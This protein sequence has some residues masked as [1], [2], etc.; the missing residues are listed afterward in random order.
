[1]SLHMR[2]S[3]LRAIFHLSHWLTKFDFV[4]FSKFLILENVEVPIVLTINMVERDGKAYMNISDTSVSTKLSYFKI[5]YQC[6]NVATVINNMVSTAVNSNW[7]LIKF[8]VDPTV[9]RF[10]GQATRHVLQPVFDA[11]PLEE[12]FNEFFI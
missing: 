6:E 8:F 10:V 2:V 4:L 3:V 11:Y 1:M 12:Y 7:K 9:D 5:N